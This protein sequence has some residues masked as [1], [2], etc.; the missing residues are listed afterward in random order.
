MLISK[1]RICLFFILNKMKDLIRGEEVNKRN[2]KDKNQ[3][4]RIIN[5]YKQNKLGQIY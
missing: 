4:K 3:Y 1:S 5:K 2:Y